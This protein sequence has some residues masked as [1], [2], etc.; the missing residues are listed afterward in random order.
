MSRQLPARSP[1]RNAEAP[2]TGSEL[3]LW[4]GLSYGIGN[5]F[6]PVRTALDDGGAYDAGAARAPAVRAAALSGGPEGTPTSYSCSPT[7]CT[8]C[9]CSTM[10]DC[11][12]TDD[13]GQL[14]FTCQH[15]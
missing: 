4:G 11:T 3:V 2:W 10:P 7:A 1:R 13:D 6:D 14:T 9:S 15:A 5:G 12:C 8:D